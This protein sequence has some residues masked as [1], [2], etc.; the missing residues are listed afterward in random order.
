MKRFVIQLLI[1]CSLFL[2][3][4][5]VLCMYNKTATQK[6]LEQE[7]VFPTQVS[8]LALGDSHVRY[9]VDDRLFPEV[10]NKAKD[11][12]AILY[13]L[14]KAN[15]YTEANTNIRTILL[16]Y[17]YCTLSPRLFYAGLFGRLTDKMYGLYFPLLIDRK[18]LLE[19]LDERKDSKNYWI[20]YAR[21]KYG[22]PSKLTL[23]SYFHRAALD[24][25]TEF[26]GGFYGYDYSRI[27]PELQPDYALR[28]YLYRYG[29]DAEWQ[30]YPKQH[31]S[32]IEMCEW[33]R[34]KNYRLVLYNA[35]CHPDFLSALPQKAVHC[36]DSIAAEI[37]LRY[38]AMYLN[39]A[40]YP[41]PDSCFWD[42][43]HLNKY[44]A[45]VITKVLRDTLIGRGY[46]C[47]K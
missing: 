42:H 25:Q 37:C 4:G 38:D 7:K 13:N 40:D 23:N 12:E 3:I 46:I 11:G 33:A 21:A 27:K 14:A 35:P 39:Y 44:G 47:H 9:S 43:D 6:I 32:L 18:N 28:K 30:I 20:A 45:E 1:I 2:T 5:V 19:Q 31:E 24:Q 22:I 10:K 17:H 41:L 36:T 8:I 29:A 34:R 26:A 16:S 15:F